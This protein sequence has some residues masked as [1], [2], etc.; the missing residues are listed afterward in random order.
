MVSVHAATVESQVAGQ[1]TVVEVQLSVSYSVSGVPSES[2]SEY[3]PATYAQVATALSA[4][5]H[6]PVTQR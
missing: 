1:T 4:S 6:E 3:V 2:A 5:A